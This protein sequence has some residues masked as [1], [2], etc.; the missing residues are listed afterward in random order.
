[1]ELCT[2]VVVSPRLVLTAASCVCSPQHAA[3]ERRRPDPADAK[4]CATLGFVR[5]RSSTTRRTTAVHRDSGGP[6]TTG[7]SGSIR[8]SSRSRRAK[9]ISSR[10]KPTWP[11]SCWTA[12]RMSPRSSWPKATSRPA[13]RSSSWATGIPPG[14][15][16]PLERVFSKHRVTQVLNS[17]GRVAFANPPS[18]LQGRPGGAVPAPDQAGTAPHWNLEREPLGKKPCSRASTRTGTGC[19]PRFRALQTREA[20]CLSPSGS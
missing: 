12:R 8:H 20:P 5:E 3:Q 10:V 11:S 15:L 2:G 9:G 18:H 19:A 14:P 7:P 4:A 6:S 1:M 13:S 17:G 16:G